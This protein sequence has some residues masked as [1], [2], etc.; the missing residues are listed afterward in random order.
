[1]PGR[2]PF[3]HVFKQTYL[4]PSQ[5]PRGTEI[6]AERPVHNSSIQDQ[7]FLPLPLL[8]NEEDAEEVFR[9]TLQT[10]SKE[11]SS[12]RAKSCNLFTRFLLSSGSQD[13]AGE[14]PCFLIQPCF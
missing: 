2:T 5:S 9:S 8:V 12:K 7:A 10:R 13:A 3:F 1:M 4:N 14:D 6:D 11:V